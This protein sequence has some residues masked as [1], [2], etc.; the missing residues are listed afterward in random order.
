MVLAL[1]VMDPLFFGQLTDA[2]QRWLVEGVVSASPATATRWA[3]HHRRELTSTSVTPR[4]LSS[5]C[6]AWGAADWSP[7]AGRRVRVG[8]SRSARLLHG[9]RRH[10]RCRSWRRRLRW[11]DGAASLDDASAERPGGRSYE[12]KRLIEACL[13]LLDRGLVLGFR[14]GG[15]SGLCDERDRG[16]RRRGMDVDITAVALREAGMAPLRS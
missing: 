13:E 9:P 14:P 2:R 3:C 6:C 5:T 11:R 15:P 4:I 8:T 16:S 7:G 10:R 1:A 12:E